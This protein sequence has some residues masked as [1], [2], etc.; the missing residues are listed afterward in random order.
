MRGAG[1]ESYCVAGAALLKWS[2]K[3]IFPELGGASSGKT[4]QP[5]RTVPSLPMLRLEHELGSKC[6]ADLSQ[7]GYGL[8]VKGRIE[9]SNISWLRALKPFRDAIHKPF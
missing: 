6:G 7:G 5:N 1:V 4:V 8:P 3:S 2:V 9:P